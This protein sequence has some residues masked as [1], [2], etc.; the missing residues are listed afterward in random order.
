MLR[1]MSVRHRALDRRA[2]T[3]FPLVL[4]MFCLVSGGPHGLEESIQQSGA[5]MGLL[6]IVLLPLMWAY[7]IAL[8]TAELSAAIPVE[9]GYYAWTKRAFGPFWG[10]MCAWWTWLYSMVDAAVYPVLFASYL[11]S[12]EK[13][14]F[15]RSILEHN[16]LIQWAV[17][18]AIIAIF[19]ALNVRGTKLVGKTAVFLGFFLILPYIA[20]AAV[21][22][23]RMLSEPGPIVR[24]F[25]P[26]GQTLTTVF[27][28]GL[29]IVMWNY[30]GWDSLSTV[31][32]EV[33]Q[34]ERN[35]PKAL[36]ICVPIVAAIYLVPVIVGL[37]FSPD[38][39]KWADGTWPLIARDV[40][41]QWLG[42]WIS[43]AGLASPI[44]L[45]VTALLAAS[46]IPFVLAEDRFFPKPLL[47]VHPRFHTP[48][49]AVILC[50]LIYA[51]LA[52]LFTFVQLIEINVT[53]YSAA[54]IVELVAL[55][56][57]RRKEPNLARPYRIA[58]G[59]A[60]LAAIVVLPLLVIAVAVYAAIIDDWHEQ[61]IVAALL[62][63]GPVIFL[64]TKR[65][66]DHSPAP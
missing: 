62:V 29:Y 14:M 50:G 54:V 63:T 41:G 36:L 39:T 19:S 2:L 21:G 65:S 49:I 26:K 51:V 35:F 45:F 23:F 61:I 55:A 7:P 17:A 32:E 4:T 48:W 5:G 24:E 9:G 46:R 57:L 60:G 64:A 28:S 16:P 8:M 66:R 27:A 43:L 20:L 15:G 52:G 1:L 34:P 22:I 31:S 58:G 40:G 33:D 37:R 30:L 18:L 47:K 25:T 38:T 44:A 6:L 56:A 42:S 12:F 11:A 59:A 13:L 3:L 10:F 53:L